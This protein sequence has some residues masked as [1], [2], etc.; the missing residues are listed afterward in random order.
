MLALQDH[1]AGCASC[2]AERRSISQVKM[3]LRALHEP[4]PSGRLPQAI[5]GRLAEADR[6]LWQTMTLAPIT[7]TPP[8][9]QRG[10][11]LMTALALSCLTVLSFAASLAPASRDGRLVTASFGL[12]LGVGALGAVPVSDMSLSPPAPPSGFLVAV[13]TERMR[14]EQAAVS[15]TGTPASSDLRLSPLPDT[16]PNAFSGAAA[17]AAYRTH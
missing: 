17:F 2:E 3:L 7:L 12:P 1:F 6:P 5:A 13:D 11:R 9:P 16:S 15:F 10:R 4:R 14:R 8:R